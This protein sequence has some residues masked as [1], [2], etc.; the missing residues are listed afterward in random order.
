MRGRSFVEFFLVVAGCIASGSLECRNDGLSPQASRGAALYARMCAVCHG[1][2]GEGYAAD[3]APALAQPNFLASASDA[4][5][6]KAVARGRAG[7]TMSA[8]SQARGGP[9]VDAD[10]DAVVA[11]LRT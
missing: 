5:L 9:L 8:W 2:S 11:Y 4:Y 3:H 7:T 1:P 6:R 10:V